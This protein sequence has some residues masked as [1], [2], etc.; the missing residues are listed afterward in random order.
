MSV[1]GKK[2]VFYRSILQSVQKATVFHL[3]VISSLIWSADGFSQIYLDSTATVDQRVE[4]LLSRM[5]LDEKIG[6]MTQADRQYLG[7][8]A[9]ITTYAL[10]SLLSGGGSAPSTNSPFAWANMYDS[11]QSRALATRLHVPMIYGIDAVHGH[12]N[13]KGAVIFP[14]N[15]GMG[16]TWNPDLVREAARI[17]AREVAGTGIDWT[18][19][20]CIAVPRDERWGRTY[21]GFGEIAD[22]T[23]MMS[24]AAVAGFQGDTLGDRQS[25]LACAKHYVGDGGT[26]GGE[27][28]G[29]A[30][31]DETTLRA[32]HLPG[33]VTAI[34]NN[35]GSVMASFSSWNGQKLHGNHY[36]LTTVLKGELNFKGFVVSDWAGIDQL[37][38]DYSSDIETSVNAG[39]DMVMVPD[40]YKT[41]IS[42]LKS[43]VQQSRVTEERIN[44]AVRRI[45]KIKFQMGLFE[46]PYTDRTLTSQIGSADHRAVARE[47][48]RQSLVLLKMKNEILPLPKDNIK[49]HVAGKNADDLGNQCGG[50]TISWQGASGN[51]TTGTTILEAIEQ[52]APNAEISYSLDGSNASGADIGIVIIGET[53]YAESQGDRSD[54]NLSKTDIAAVRNIKNTGIPVIVILISGR[55]LILSPVL[56]FCDALIAAWLPGTEG[57]G[58]AD[59]LFGEFPPSGRLSHSWPKNMQ[60]IPINF[61]DEDYDP[62]FEYGYGI[63]S[64]AGSPSGSPPQLYSAATNQDGSAIEVTFNKAMTDPAA[65][66]TSFTIFLNDVAADPIQSLNLKSNDST[67]IVLNLGQS[68]ESGDVIKISYQAGTLHSADGGMLESFA[69]YEVYNLLND[70]SAVA[71]I[72]GRIQ[73]ENYSRMHGVQTENTTD[74]G[75]G[76]DVGYIDNYDWLQY[77]VNIKQGGS[78]QLAFRIASLSQAGQITLISSLSGS[79]ARVSLPVTGEWQ[80]WQTVYTEVQLKEGLQALNLV[81]ATGGFNINWFE[82]TLLTNVPEPMDQTFSFQLH[83][84]YP[85]P[86]NHNTIINYEIAASSPVEMV[87]FDILGNKIKT[88]VCE[89]QNA[90][91]YSVQFNATKLSSGLYFCQLKAGAISQIRKMVLT[92]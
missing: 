25:I 68:A 40:D 36:L 56:H 22:L 62:L 31:L 76:L 43:L 71:I 27:D 74:I 11:F 85:N 20:P 81:A 48:V 35:V 73:A 24:K 26:A 83:Q 33:Y 37:P 32:I 64:F 59:V 9:D 77:D 45:L 6:Q 10:G 84:N 49:I 42:T 30:Q 72:P 82:F 89:K 57:Q 2:L 78:Y 8:E 3:L 5:T 17:T 63:T 75:G 18:F 21:E 14:H 4:D 19:A 16:C 41:F 69:G 34:E 23:K 50:W 54:L 15:I 13:V 90:G 51:I 88:L 1:F 12:N 86:F 44:D 38:G 39:I 58:I 60:Q 55:P 47:C 87:I 28:Q 80:T 91:N 61:G 65:E 70:A 46:R 52:A 7:N 66:M 29:D 53:P 92:K 67:T 79:V